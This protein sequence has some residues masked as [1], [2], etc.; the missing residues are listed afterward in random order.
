VID[1]ETRLFITGGEP[2]G[3]ISYEVEDDVRA[4]IEQFVSDYAADLFPEPPWNIEGDFKPQFYAEVERRTRSA[5]ADL[6]TDGQHK[7]YT[8]IFLRAEEINDPE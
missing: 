8:G 6:E 2:G 3:W 5:I 1:G 7:I 4:C